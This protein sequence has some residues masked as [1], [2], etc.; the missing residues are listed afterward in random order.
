M[1]ILLLWFCA[2]PGRG[3]PN[4]AKYRRQSNER[5]K[6]PAW[7]E[8]SFRYIASWSSARSSGRSKSE[9]RLPRKLVE[10]FRASSRTREPPDEVIYEAT[11]SAPGPS[12]V[13]THTVTVTTSRSVAFQT[14][15][16][17]RVC[18]RIA[19]PIAFYPPSVPAGEFR[20]WTA[21]YADMR[22]LRIEW[23]E[24]DRL[25]S[26]DFPLDFAILAEP[27]YV[28]HEVGRA[29]SSVEAYRARDRRRIFL[30]RIKT[31]P[32]ASRS[33]VLSVKVPFVF[34]YGHTSSTWSK[35]LLRL[36]NVKRVKV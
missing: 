27:C 25:I 1:S 5:R 20:P 35:R 10:A 7:S 30:A 21:R 16:V 14:C 36:C 26:L 2:L 32:S 28:R 19:A 12:L 29:T 9:I 34:H 31:W 23:R 24:T 18:I 17:A 8:A 4:D 15:V 3:I 6:R 22:I 33:E 11:L 13:L